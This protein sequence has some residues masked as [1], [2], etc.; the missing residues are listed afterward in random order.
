MRLA[1]IGGAASLV[2]VSAA[3]AQVQQGERVEVTGSNIRR[4]QSET[5]SPVT[6]LTR[7]DLDRSGKTSVAELLQTLSIDNQGSVPISFGNGFSRSGSGISLRGLGVGATLVLINGRRVA[8]FPLA[9]DGT[10]QY[11]DLNILPLEAVERIEILK[12]GGSAVYGSDAIAGVVNI[13]LRKDY[14]GVQ[15]HASVGQSLQYGDGRQT[16]VSITGGYG[17]LDTDRFSS[18]LN[19]EYKKQE[20]IYYSNRTDRGTI[21]KADLRSDGFNYLDTT[22]GGASA[23]GLGYI[24]NQGVASNSINGSVRDPFATTFNGVPSTANTIYY[25]RGNLNAGTGFTRQFPGAA[26]SNFTSQAQGDPNGGCI[27]DQYQ[28]YRQVIPKSEDFNLYGRVNFALTDAI[29]AYVDGQI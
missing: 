16:E 23:S 1:F 15:L 19:L 7:E 22:A 17:N 6:T 5:A 10:K 27:I 21:G 18:I 25:N 8:P 13:I 29:T 28:T 20:P 2:L 3:Q 4:V 9:D 14:S 12:D 26:C 24:T 11:T